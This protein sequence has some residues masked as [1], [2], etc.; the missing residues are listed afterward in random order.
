M[1]AYTTRGGEGPFPTQDESL[2]NLMHSMGREYGAVTG[3]HH[4]CG[5]FDAVAAGG[6][7]VDNDSGAQPQRRVRTLK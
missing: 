6:D 1:K 4:R 3:R 2:A 5:W 7:Q